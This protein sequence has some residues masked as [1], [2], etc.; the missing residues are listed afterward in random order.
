MTEAEWRAC[1]DPW[2]MLEFLQG[3]ASD[4]KLRLFAC[5]C[6]RHHAPFGEDRELQEAVALTERHADGMLPTAE[7]PRY[8]TFQ[9][10]SL[11]TGVASGIS[12][13]PGSGW[14]AAYRC[15]LS[16]SSG[17]AREAAAQCRLLRC[18]LG[19]PFRPVRPDPAWQNPHAMA[20]A[21]T[22]YDDRRWEL[23]PLMA[24]LLEEAGC[25]AAVSEHCRSEGPHMRGCWVVDLVL[26]KE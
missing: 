6:C 14:R 16:A 15:A 20:L 7:Y 4:R 8:N 11:I 19:N 13:T 10:H 1:D 26:G 25:P 21:R 17:N 9:H 2:P 23:L 24:D 3:K 12:Q 18:V 22:I 5:A